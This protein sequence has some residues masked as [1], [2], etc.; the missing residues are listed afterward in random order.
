MIDV[1]KIGHAE[2][3]R[4]LYNASRPFGLG[5]LH[6]KDQ[7]MTLEEAKQLLEQTNSFDYLY[8]RLIK[9]CIE[10]VIDERLYDRD[11]GEGA[12]MRALFPEGSEQ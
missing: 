8:G 9:V 7:D 6:F 11:L 2:A 3:L 1:T 10:D 5:F 4:R 12:A